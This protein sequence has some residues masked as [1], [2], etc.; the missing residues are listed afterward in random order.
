M[1]SSQ[2]NGSQDS[3]DDALDDIWGDSR[4]TAPAGKVPTARPKKEGGSGSADQK[5]RQDK[6][7]RQAAGLNSEAAQP[8]QTKAELKRQK[9]VAASGELVDQAKAVIAE[10]AELDTCKKITEK[11]FKSLLD[12]LQTRL[13]P[14]FVTLY[15]ADYA[16][17]K[18]APGLPPGPG[19]CGMTVLEDL[20]KV[21]IEMKAFKPLVECMHAAEGTALSDATSLK[22][23]M[24]SVSNAGKV[25][26]KYLQRLLLERVLK[27][28]VAPGAGK[29]TDFGEFAR[30]MLQTEPQKHDDVNLS[31][32]AEEE[33]EA[34]QTNEVV[35]ALVTLLRAAENSDQVIAF[36][37]AFPGNIIMNQMLRE[38]L[39]DLR[40]LTSPMDPQLLRSDVKV[41]DGTSP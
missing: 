8:A 40:I 4:I 33:R 32:L 31:C 17:A 3:I 6:Q 14:A 28:S 27:S 30:V 22:A 20:N 36:L 29:P 2:T 15:S 21:V 18:C 24:S 19:H 16:D 35:K 12:K 23:A 13:A 11:A 9:E 5:P 25:V 1:R 37:T 41:D 7:A 26:P 10:L 38:E 34:F 39:A